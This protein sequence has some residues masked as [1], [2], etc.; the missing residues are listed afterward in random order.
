MI[1]ASRLKAMSKQDFGVITNELTRTRQTG[2]LLTFWK[3]IYWKKK[4]EGEDN[5]SLVDINL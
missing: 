3:E 5:A 4:R 2:N 1:R